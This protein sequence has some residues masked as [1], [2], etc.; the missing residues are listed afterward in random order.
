MKYKWN[1]WEHDDNS[2]FKYDKKKK[3]LIIANN[4]NKNQLII[5]FYETV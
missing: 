2:L 3:T 5:W 4:H 1:K